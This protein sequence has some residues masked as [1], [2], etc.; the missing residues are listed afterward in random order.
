MGNLVF[1]ASIG[2]GKIKQTEEKILF[3]IGSQEFKV[4]E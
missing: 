3:S 4:V 1:C 2:L